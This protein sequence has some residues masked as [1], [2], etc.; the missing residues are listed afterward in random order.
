[1][2]TCSEYDNKVNVLKR[3]H[4]YIHIEKALNE[5]IDASNW[6]AKFESEHKADLEHVL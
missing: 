5:Y 2:V 6:Y 3:T 1:M 4:K